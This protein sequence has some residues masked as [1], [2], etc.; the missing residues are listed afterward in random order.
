[1]VERTEPRTDG[2]ELTV[3]AGFLD[4]YRATLLMKADGLTDLAGT[5][6][7]H[8]NWRAMLRHGLEAGDVSA[9]EEAAIEARIRTGRPLGDE[10]FVE[11]LEVASGRGLKPRKRG[12]KAKAII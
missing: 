7:L 10:A 11:R 8:R 2:D 9:A 4:Y 3:L 12:P 6:G 5:A 1:M